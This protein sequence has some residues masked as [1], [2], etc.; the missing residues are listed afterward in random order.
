MASAPEGGPNDG[1]TLFVFR[2]VFIVVGLLGAPTRAPLSPRVET[3]VADP[4]VVLAGDVGGN[5]RRAP[6]VRAR[7][8]PGGGDV[9]LVRAMNVGVGHDKRA[10]SRA[11]VDR[12]PAG[13]PIHLRV[14]EGLPWSD[15]IGWFTLI[16][17]LG[18]VVSGAI[19]F[20]VGLLVARVSSAPPSDETAPVTAPVRAP[21]G[22]APR[23]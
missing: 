11:P 14:A 19:V 2:R 12:R 23:A 7:W 22:R 17:T 4:E 15:T 10:T 20:P 21:P 18:A 3:T 9:A 1:A 6:R 5:P 16:W 8:P 13:S